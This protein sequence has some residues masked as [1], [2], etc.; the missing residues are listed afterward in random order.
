[1]PR[2]SPLYTTAELPSTPTQWGRYLAQRGS[3]KGLPYGPGMRQTLALSAY[4]A[5]R[6]E[7]AR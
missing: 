3:L 6:S 1:M 4:H 5:A 7:M 2:N